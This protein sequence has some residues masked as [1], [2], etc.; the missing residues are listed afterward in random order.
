MLGVEDSGH[1]VLP[2]PHPSR[3]GAWSLVGDG[4]ATLCAMLLS[5][6]RGRSAPF[7]RGWKKRTSVLDSHRDRWHAQSEVFASVADLAMAALN[8]D[9][10]VSQQRRIAGEADLLLVHATK[11][12]HVVSLGVRNSGTQ[13]KT[14]VSMRLSPGLETGP[15]EDLLDRV[16]QKL[17]MALTDD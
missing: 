12:E 8:A 2:S 17:T 5:M 1:I 14:S 4:A 9:G 15:Y 6:D 11:G 13:A 7:V 10:F 3:E 16:V